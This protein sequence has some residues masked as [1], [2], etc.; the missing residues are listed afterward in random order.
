ME[1]YSQHTQHFL[2]QNIQIVR[3]CNNR[4]TANQ[5]YQCRLKN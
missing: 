1:S 4:Q 3:Q 5:I 2:H